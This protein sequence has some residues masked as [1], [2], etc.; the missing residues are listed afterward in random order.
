MRW[1]VDLPP[2]PYAPV[3]T[4]P[5]A[6]GRDA[7]SLFPVVFGDLLLVNTADQILAW[8]VRTGKPA[9]PVDHS[10]KENVQSAV[11][12][13]SG[14]ETAS[15]LATAP[16]G[17]APRY[18]L[19]VSEGRLYARLG[20]PTTTRPRDDP[21]ES[22][23]FLVCLDLQRGEGKLLWKVD[24][25]VLDAQAAF[26]GSPLVIDG[27]AYAVV[28]RGRPQMLTDVACFDTET[29]RRLWER[30]VCAAVANVGQGDGLLSHDLLTA[31]DNAVF[32]STGTGA[33]AAPGSRGGRPAMDRDL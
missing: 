7:L 31:G 5:V 9:W 8:N 6:N 18:T 26:E 14:N 28:R 4:G 21:R 25:G 12:Y 3:S 10:P 33:V 32:L 30:P 22:D 1:A 29:G 23:S 15:N 13:P 2:D 20:D 16:P 17:G 24:A 19:T 27:R 11:I